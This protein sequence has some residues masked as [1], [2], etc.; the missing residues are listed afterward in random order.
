[1]EAF[2]A[3]HKA[4]KYKAFIASHTEDKEDK[5]FIASRNEQ[6]NKTRT[7]WRFLQREALETR[8]LKGVDLEPDLDNLT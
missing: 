3:S 2:V 1:M 7:L 8:Q 4:K 6:K 5:A